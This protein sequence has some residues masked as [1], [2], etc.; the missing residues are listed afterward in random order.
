MPFE[1]ASGVTSELADPAEPSA[2]AASLSWLETDAGL[3]LVDGASDGEAP[4]AAPVTEKALR[5]RVAAAVEGP[6]S[7]SL[8]SPSRP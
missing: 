7:G 1:E 4:L 6:L 2:A 3:W 8:S 5:Q